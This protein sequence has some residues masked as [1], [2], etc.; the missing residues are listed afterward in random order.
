M[1]AP[2]YCEGV[3]RTK[4]RRGPWQSPPSPWVGEMELGVGRLCGE[5]PG[6]VP[7][8]GE[9]PESA[10]EIYGSSPSSLQL[11]TEPTVPV[12]VLPEARGVG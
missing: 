7:E 9:R 1:I 12:R 2:A 6:R 10:L 4:C 3:S 8:Q 11:T 5:F